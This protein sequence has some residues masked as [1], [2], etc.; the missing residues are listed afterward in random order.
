VSPAAKKPRRWTFYAIKYNGTVLKQRFNNDHVNNERT[1]DDNHWKT[2][3]NLPDLVIQE[4]Q[5]GVSPPHYNRFFI[6]VR[7]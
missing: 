6:F 5:E 3:V 7:Q 4:W 2:I 1:V